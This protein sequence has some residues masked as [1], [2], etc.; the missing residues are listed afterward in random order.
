MP[1]ELTKGTS[2]VSVRQMPAAPC[3]CPSGVGLGGCH[4]MSHS[5]SFAPSAQMSGGE[6]VP[7]I[8]W[9]EPHLPFS[10]F[11][12]CPPSYTVTFA[13][14]GFSSYGNRPTVTAGLPSGSVTTMEQWSDFGVTNM[15]A[16]AKPAFPRTEISTRS[17]ACADRWIEWL[18]DREKSVMQAVPS[19]NAASRMIRVFPSAS[20][21]VMAF[22]WIVFFLFISLFERC[23]SDTERDAR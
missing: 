19:G 23:H 20:V 17:S 6:A 16:L 15:V 1:S 10:R 13:W 22:A 8:C 12:A 5:C 18:P 3:A 7:T 21:S 14:W 2:P 9:F 11:T 4:D